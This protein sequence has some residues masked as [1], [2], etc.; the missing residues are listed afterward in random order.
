MQEDITVRDLISDIDKRLTVVEK[1]LKE[2]G[3]KDK[4]DK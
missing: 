2:L 4:K 3:E 1:V